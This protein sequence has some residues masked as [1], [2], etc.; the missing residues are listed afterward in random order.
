MYGTRLRKRLLAMK[1]AKAP[2]DK[3]KMALHGSSLRELKPMFRGVVK[4]RADKSMAEHR[5][6]MT[7]QW[8]ITRE[9]QDHL[10]QGSHRELTA[11][12]DD[13]FVADLPVKRSIASGRSEASTLGDCHSRLAGTDTDGRTRQRR[14]G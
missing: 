10:T 13:G 11:T 3:V 8:P 5:D 9:A 2:P 7:K 6:E 4:A 14:R 12:Y 1:R